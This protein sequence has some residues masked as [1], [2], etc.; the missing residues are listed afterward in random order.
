MSNKAYNPF[1]SRYLNGLQKLLA[2]LLED[3]SLISLFS[4]C[5]QKKRT[6]RAYLPNLAIETM[7][8]KLDSR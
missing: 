7:R 1:S 5:F 6:I 8:M 3:I 4:N 2:E